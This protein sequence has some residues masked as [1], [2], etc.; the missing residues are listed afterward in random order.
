[1]YDNIF[2]RVSFI[3]FAIVVTIFILAPA[4]AARV[5]KPPP[6]I[7]KIIDTSPVSISPKGVTPRLRTGDTCTVYAGGDII[8]Y[9]YPWVI[10]DELYKAYQDPSL[11]CDKPYPF[12]VE[13]VHFALYFVDTGTVF[14]SV[15]VEGVDQT[16]P[17]CP[18]PDT[19]LAITPLYQIEITV[20]SLYMVTFLLDTPVVINGP[21]FVGA[22]FADAGTPTSC[23]VVT[24]TFPE[25]CISYNDWGDGYVDLDTVYNRTDPLNPFKIFPGRLVLFSSGTT[26]GMSG[27]QPAPAARF[28]HPEHNQ[29]LGTVVDLWANDAAGSEIIDRARFQYYPSDSWVDIGTDDNDDPPI[30]NGVTPSG[31]GDGLSYSWNTGG[32]QENDYQLRVI[33]SDTLGRADT[34]EVSVHIDP[35]PPTP[36]FLQ[37]TFG[38]NVCASIM[39]QLSCTDEDLTYMTFDIKNAS[40][41]FSLPL[42]V[43]DQQLGGNVD[44]DPGDGNSA[45]EGEYGDYCSGPA[46]A[47]MAVRYWFNKGYNYLLT[48]GTTTLTDTQLM[49]RLFSAMHIRENLGSHDGEFVSG[50][51][52]YIVAHGNQLDLHIDRQPTMAML[53]SWAEDYEYIVMVGISGNPGVWMT[54]AGATGPADCDGHYVLSMAN[55]AAAAINDFTAKEESDKLWILYDD[56]WVEV[57]IMVGA[58]PFDWTVSRTAVGIDANPGDGL[59]FYWDTGSLDEDSLYFLF[60]TVHDADGNKG[61]ASVLTYIDCIVDY[62]P[63]DVD[64][65]GSVTPADIVYLTNFLYGDG[66]PPVTGHEAADV[67]CDG[68]VDISDVIYLHKYLFLSGP[69]PCP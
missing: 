42:T 26:G 51:R 22:Y 6:Q 10:G 30:R 18:K 56:T 2:P 28:I 8:Y 40:R 12:T 27:D 1:M 46:A 52:E 23:A 20:P 49:D 44:D 59:Q 34:S 14:I 50:L 61:Y 60:A 38:Q 54:I 66:P 68:S 65:D 67:N 29:F 57:D 53:R 5:A 3:L 4:G 9:I 48:E 58:V 36:E 33:V 63:G 64:N 37:P 16:D 35:T 13:N 31:T 69:P 32:L 17:N 45:S 15:D 62:I 7:N 39:A 11:S 19:I 41:A 47:A 25:P 55:P 24:D 21:Y 43:I